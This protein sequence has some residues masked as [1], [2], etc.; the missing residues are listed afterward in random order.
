[1]DG[2]EMNQKELSGFYLKEGHPKYFAMPKPRGFCHALNLRLMALQNSEK[3]KVLGPLSRQIPEPFIKN[4][5]QFRPHFLFA[6]T[7]TVW[8][9]E[10]RFKS[11]YLKQCTVLRF[12]H[13]LHNS[14]NIDKFE[15]SCLIFE[16]FLESFLELFLE[17]FLEI[18]W[19]LLDTW[20]SWF[21]ITIS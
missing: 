19:N 21:S 4:L 14:T 18:A 8:G 12:S 5:G 9:G 7:K 15:I 11:V 6:K 13:T 17:I 10:S 20:K 3:W 1:M 2:R 16:I